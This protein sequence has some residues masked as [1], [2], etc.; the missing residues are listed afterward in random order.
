MEW[1][2]EEIGK[3]IKKNPWPFVVG[4]GAGLLFLLVVLSKKGEDSAS[5]SY[6]I[7][8]DEYYPSM[9]GPAG[10]PAGGGST[11]IDR[12]Y[13]IDFGNAMGL[14]IQ[15]IME[16]SMARQLAWQEAFAIQQQDL[17]QKLDSRQRE[18]F[19]QLQQQYID[20][21]Q[22]LYIDQQFRQTIPPVQQEVYQSSG[23]S[24]RGSGRVVETPKPYKGITIEHDDYYTYI[25]STKLPGGIHDP[26][27]SK[28]DRIDAGG[29]DMTREEKQKAIKELMERDPR[30]GGGKVRYENGKAVWV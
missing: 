21:L 18:M 15:D 27:R 25:P 19:Y 14:M 11:G 22:Q 3:N 1:K 26:N 23:G 30:P 8:A 9:G 24:S 7:P 29:H 2:I 28:S 4:G 17:Y 16:E 5:P 13:L 10:G 20:Q 6:T 12:E